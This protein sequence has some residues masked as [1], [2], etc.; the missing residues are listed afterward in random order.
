MG[1]MDES[2]GMGGMDESCGMSGISGKS[3][4]SGKDGKM[5][6]FADYLHK[7]LVLS[8]LI[9]LVSY[10][11]RSRLCTIVIYYILSS[12]FILLMLSRVLMPFGHRTPRKRDSCFNI[13]SSPS[14]FVVYCTAFVVYCVLPW[15]SH[16]VIIFK[17]RVGEDKG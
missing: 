16:C 5:G 8:R 14:G 6:K 3:G 9:I 7:Y 4:N 15:S 12:K 1:G 2:C 10:C 13:A 17:V 11:F